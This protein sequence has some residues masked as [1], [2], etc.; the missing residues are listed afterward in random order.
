M[1]RTTTATSPMVL[2][3]NDAELFDSTIRTNH[4]GFSGNGF[5]DYGGIGSYAIWMVNIPV[6]GSYQLRI[7]Y[8]LA[9]NRRPISVLLGGGSNKIGEFQIE[10]T[11]SWTNWMT[12]TIT[13]VLSAGNRQELKFL[14]DTTP[15]P[16]VDKVDL[17]PL[18][19]AVPNNPTLK[20]VLEP[21]ESLSRNQFVSSE[22]D[23]YETGLDSRGDLIVR[24]KALSTV[25]WSL[26]QTIA[27]SVPGD[28]LFLQDDGNLVI[29]DSHRRAVWDSKTY[30]N[31]D[32]RFVI[33]NR[34]TIAVIKSNQQEL[35]TGGPSSVPPA[36][37][38]SPSLTQ[39]P[40]PRPTIGVLQPSGDDVYTAVL[41]PNQSLPRNQFVSSQSGVYET[42]LDSRGDLVV[43]NKASSTVLWSLSQTIARN[44]PGDRIFMQDDGNLVIRDTNRRAV[45]D[46]KTYSN[47]GARFAINNRGTIA[48][49]YSNQ[50]ELWIGGLDG[51][52]GP[53]GGPSTSPP[54]PSPRP[55]VT[56]NPTP[57]PI[58]QPSGNVASTTILRGNQNFG[59]G[60]F[61]DSP[62][63]KYRV[64]LNNA[65]NLVML[66]GNV[67]IWR[68]KDKQRRDV[69]QV[70]RAF[71]QS[72]GNLV[73]RDS[74]G[75]SRW[76][77]ETSNLAG[78]LLR[79]DDRG[80][81]Y[82]VYKG[83]VVWM[84]GLPRQM[85]RGPSSAD[86]VFPVRGM[87]Y[88]AWY[89]ET[90]EVGG[91]EVFYRPNLGAIPQ[92]PYRSG[93][94]VVVREHVK[95]LDYAYADL[96]IISWW[97]VS[98]RLDRARITQLMDETDRQNSPIKWTVYYEPEMANDFSVEELVKDLNYLKEW[99]AWH[100][101]WAH[102]NGKPVIFVW[103]ESSCN[104]ANRWEEAGRRANWYV[105]LKIFPRYEDCP[106][107]PDSWH[108][109][110]VANDVIENPP[111]SFCI[112]PGFWRADHPAPRNPRV[113]RT[114]FCEQVAKMN[115]SGRDW[116]LVVSF[117]EWGEG[118]AVES[119]VEWN[120]ASGYGDYL[121]CLHDPV[122]FG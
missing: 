116:Q 29:R 114:R 117:N 89:P 81:L 13:V 33:S 53:V 21:N 80:L 59:I 98:N 35:W 18:G 101:T 48:V 86:L 106:I 62:N 103:N 110:G 68:L 28:R 118:T 6:T 94:P 100:P 27:R 10:S 92:G 58:Q 90:W 65:G 82:I 17:I 31:S 71:L 14:A 70:T 95:A 19:T 12:E 66:E 113:G 50:Q 49:I 109:Y 120:S 67:I 83:T 112:A 36:Q 3:A 79:I 57:Q 26:S 97:G 64:G 104:V 74:T 115:E 2:A 84:D 102:I 22:S 88:Y 99:F 73:L 119:A 47:S 96:G 78:S 93:D 75:R 63:R 85:Y 44:V 11:N 52:S 16:N 45:W 108:Q 5:I 72:D 51:G 122:R 7:R 121:D 61:F 54:A 46:S 25:L 42:G 40:T 37:V 23:I 1:R 56:P 87:F 77:S 41:N 91:K 8:A 4:V 9:M 32:A 39:N 24:D 105:V 107:Q 30:G 43:R 20:I 76:N 15:G 69:A 60:T 34:G 111:Y 38:P 55:V